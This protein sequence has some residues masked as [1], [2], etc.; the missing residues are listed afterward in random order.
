LVPTLD[1]RKR[2]G[3]RKRERKREREEE[4]MIT[5][6]LDHLSLSPRTQNRRKEFIPANCPLTS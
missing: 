4:E 5:L 2:E 6:K 1:E 3:G